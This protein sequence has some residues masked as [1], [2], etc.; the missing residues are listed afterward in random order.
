M[1]VVMHCLA[2]A[3]F[4]LFLPTVMAE[5]VDSDMDGFDDSDDMCPDQ[6]GNSTFDRLGCLDTVSY[7]HLR[8]H[9]T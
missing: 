8:A 9:E 6:Y 1:R 7:T 4:L 3:S 2:I 5:V